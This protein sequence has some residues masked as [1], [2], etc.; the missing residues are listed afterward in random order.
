M[1]DVR[2]L[3]IGLG[4][5]PSLAR[6]GALGQITSVKAHALE[7]ADRRFADIPLQRN[8]NGGAP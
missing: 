2:E 3:A 8:G 6:G 4:A 7:R 1:A 5:S